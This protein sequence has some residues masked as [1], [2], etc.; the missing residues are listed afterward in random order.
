MPGKT[1]ERA[2]ERYRRGATLASYFFK[3]GYTLDVI[4]GGSAHG[5]LK[6]GSPL[7]LATG[8]MHMS[9]S[10]IQTLWRYHAKKI[11]IEKTQFCGFCSQDI[12]PKSK[13]KKC[14]ICCHIFHSSI[15]CI[16]K[17]RKANW[18]CRRCIE[19]NS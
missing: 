14:L 4:D 8:F 2:D 16:K 5:S 12:D 1:K 9:K 7:N 13:K 3:K 15:I 19:L 6:I 10:A 11:F 17:G 18:S